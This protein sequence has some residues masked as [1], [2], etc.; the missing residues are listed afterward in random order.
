MLLLPVLFSQFGLALVYQS[1]LKLFTRTKDIMIYVADT[2]E[3][4]NEVVKTFTN[5]QQHVRQTNHLVLK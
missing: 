1:G 2:W 5:D 3:L 4:S